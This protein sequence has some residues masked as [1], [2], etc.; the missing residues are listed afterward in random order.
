MGKKIVHMGIDDT[1]SSK[2]GCTTY[3]LALI[4]EK[5]F[6]KFPG[7]VRF[8]DY[9]N[10]VRL[11][12]NIPWKTRGNGAVALRIE[13][14]SSILERAQNLILEVVE[15]NSMVSEG[16][17]PAVVFLEGSLTKEA[18]S[19]G[20]RVLF[21]VV[22]EHEAKDLAKRLK[23][24]V[25][26]LSGE[27]GV[28]G[29][30]GAVCNPLTE[31]YTFELLAYRTP[32]RRGTPRQV[33]PESVLK[34]DEEMRDVTFNN[35]DPETSRILI[36][37]RG[38]DPVL[39]GIRG[40]TPEAVLQAACM[41]EVGEPIE[42]WVIFRTNQGTDAHLAV[43]KKV[44]QLTPHTPARVLAEVRS[45]PKTIA[46]GH[47]WLLV[48]DET[49]CIDCM[50]YEPSGDLRNAVLKLKKGDVIE[51]YGGVRPPTNDKPITLNLEKIIVVKLAPYHSLRNPLCPIC[52]KRA[53]SAGRG[54]GYKCS[55]CGWRGYGEKE[56]IAVERELRPGFFVSSPRS[57]RHLTKP[58][59]RYGKEKR[60]E[61][62][63]LV[64]KWWGLGK[65]TYSSW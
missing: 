31:D 47:A 44:C 15:K 42:R 21:E 22:G 10:L 18:L 56:R 43:R 50:G 26:T 23:A 20:K 2:G 35:I 48:G 32:E 1:D 62:P 25:Y 5:L 49:G 51:V 33:L 52:G 46:G 29:A 13:T 59:C 55:R 17:Q 27:K 39:F 58:L 9:P 14:S 38:P 41:V 4:V 53:K 3:V 30:M 19:F 8:L 12:P 61:P 64:P 57:Q 65:P 11:N 54:R 45:E 40:E 7:Q 63:R 60:G 6:E 37:P 24:M 16:A 36:T 34:M 28:V